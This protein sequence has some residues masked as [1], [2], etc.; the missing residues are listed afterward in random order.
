MRAKHWFFVALIL[1]GALFLFH[2]YISHGGT[3][4]VK[5]G[6]GLGGMG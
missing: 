6:L 3:A 1:V 4:G 2:N 5:S